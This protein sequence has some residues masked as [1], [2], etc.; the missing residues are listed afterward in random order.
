M[1]TSQ[2]ES[3]PSK[4]I[5]IVAMDGISDQQPG[6]S[7]HAIANVLRYND[8]KSQYSAWTEK[9]ISI[10]V[11]PITTSKSE[12]KVFWQIDERGKSIRDALK[13]QKEIDLDQQSHKFTGDFLN[14]STVS[15]KKS[16]YDTICIKGQ[17]ENK[18]VHLYEMYWA[19]LSRLGTGFLQF[20]SEFYQILF[21]LSSLG[22][23]S[24]DMA[25]LEHH[26]SR[27]WRFYSCLYGWAVRIFTLPIPILS[28]FLLVAAFLS[29]PGLIPQDSMPIVAT[30]IST[31]VSTA[32]IGFILWKSIVSF[33]LLEKPF[34]NLGI[35]VI[36]AIVTVIVHG[37]LNN[38][39]LY[40]KILAIAWLV[41]LSFLIAILIN[42]YSLRRPGASTVAIGLGVPLFLAA[43]WNLFVVV[44]NSHKGIT[45]LSFKLIEIIYSLVA[46]SWIIFYGLYVLIVVFGLILWYQDKKNTTNT[47]EVVERTER[48]LWTACVSLFI[49]TILFIS[50]TT[51]L[52]S[53]LKLSVLNIKGVSVL[54]KYFIYSP[55]DWFTKLPL[56]QT[57][58]KFVEP[59]EFLD[60]LI[61]DPIFGIGTGIV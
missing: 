32:I 11:E 24:I 42:Q 46:T 44:E 29:L 15:R 51:T 21:H 48:A 9:S 8:E 3:V 54:P 56:T 7:V 61:F 59:V 16:G 58:G 36:T 22:R 23:Q 40:Y 5:A 39:I 47:K 17:V 27:L 41:I 1:S 37:L 18:E 33:K 26:N 12:S 30:V 52:W 6:D 45:V 53:V 14:D 19:D 28:L 38:N 60:S 49:S 34:I 20:F 2:S 50:A 57:R 4:K 31:L 13:E 25:A 55:S 43:I 35:I 10:P